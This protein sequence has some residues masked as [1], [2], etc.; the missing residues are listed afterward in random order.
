MINKLKSFIKVTS[1]S[2][3]YWCGVFSEGDYIPL[4]AIA[5][6]AQTFIVFDFFNS[7]NY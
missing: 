4:I 1:V 6:V 7:D 3:G 5:I 2:I